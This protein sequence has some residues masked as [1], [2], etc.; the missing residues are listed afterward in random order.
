MLGMLYFCAN[1]KRIL[2]LFACITLLFCLQGFKKPSKNSHKTTPDQLGRMLFFDKILSGDKSIACASCHNPAFAYADT[3]AFSKGVN[4]KFTARNSPSVMNMASREALFWDGRATTLEE[5]VLAPIQNPNEMNCAIAEVV[6]RLNHSKKYTQLFSEVF[7]QKPS[8]QNLEIA[9]ASFEKTLETSNTA[10]DRWLNDQPDGLNEQQI[11][12]R[13]VFFNKG[14]CIEC[15]YTPDFTGDEFKNIGLFD[16][17][18]WNDSGRYAVTKNVSD[19]GKF[20]VPGLRNCSITA[21]YMHDG[22]FKTLAQVIDFYNEPDK[23]IKATTPR[24]S[25]IA[26]PLGMSKTEMLDLEAFLNGMTD[27]SFEK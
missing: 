16:G 4:G 21:P 19:I 22:S 2:F 13:T 23:Y 10:N 6:Y 20:K 27:K 14:K 7:N 15:H 18:T 17:A 8:E 9:I 24:D 26:S 25:L 3:V 5:Q 1:M 11:R 12:G